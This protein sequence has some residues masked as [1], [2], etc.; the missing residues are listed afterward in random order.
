ML[1][2]E[3]KVR[4]LFAVFLDAIFFYSYHPD[5]LLTDYHKS[6]RWITIF[7]GGRWGALQVFLYAKCHLTS[8]QNAE[9][10]NRL[11][12]L[13]DQW[14]NIEQRRR[15]QV[16]M[17]V[18]TAGRVDRSSEPET[19]EFYLTAFSQANSVAQHF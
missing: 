17:D 5:K 14:S 10:K 2:G 12:W 8:L 1:A 3:E 18:I 15:V 19:A 6:H 11:E 16:I 4:T 13:E 9:A 7:D